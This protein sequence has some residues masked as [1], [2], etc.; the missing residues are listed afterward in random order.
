M[1]HQEEQAV[2]AA[3]L[4]AVRA[5]GLGCSEEL[6]S[7][8]SGDMELPLY[9]GCC[10]ACCEGHLPCGSVCGG[11]QHA[12]CKPCCAVLPWASGSR[13]SALRM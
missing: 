5:R 3:A 10:V 7:D 4:V 9:G 12:W 6:P 2:T 1:Q 13:T 8:V 11:G